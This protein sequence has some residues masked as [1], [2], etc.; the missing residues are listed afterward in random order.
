[1][2]HRN[3]TS[4]SFPAP[5]LRPPLC[6]RRALIPATAIVAISLL[7]GCGAGASSQQATAM[8]AKPAPSASLPATPAGTTDPDWLGYH[9]NQ[10]RTGALASG[11]SFGSASVAWTADLGGAVRGQAVSAGGLIVAATENNRVVALDPASGRVLWSD[12][13]GTPL[14]NVASVAGCGNVDPLGSRAPR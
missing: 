14:T 3:D 4:G 8:P 5:A 11:P 12:S 6:S 2:D 10:A 1:M 7:A 13:L 9:A